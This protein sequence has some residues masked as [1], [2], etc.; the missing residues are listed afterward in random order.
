MISGES[1]MPFPSVMIVASAATDGSPQPVRINRTAQACHQLS[2]APV[3]HPQVG[4][5]PM[6]DALPARMK[7][8]LAGLV[9]GW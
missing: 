5:I 7:N 2:P 4:I 3:H 8:K 9:S 6:Q 1:A